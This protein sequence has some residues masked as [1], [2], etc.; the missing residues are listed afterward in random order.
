MAVESTASGVVIAHNHPSG[1]IVPS[2]QDKIITK[3]LKDALK[4]FEISLLD[5]VIIGDQVYFSFSDD[6]L[7]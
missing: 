2:E 4:L 7:L 3:K 1:Q 5:H 6:G